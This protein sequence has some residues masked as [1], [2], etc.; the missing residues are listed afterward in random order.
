MEKALVPAKKV[1]LNDLA[2]MGGDKP[3]AAVRAATKDGNA[4][5]QEAAT[6]CLLAWPDTAAIPDMLS[7]ARSGDAKF[8]TLALRGLVQVME[9][10][11]NRAN[12]DTY[13]QMLSI[14]S[15]PAEKKLVIAG[16]GNTRGPGALDLLTPLLADNDVKAEAATSIIK[17][18]RSARGA[19]A[20]AALQKVVDANISDDITNR[21]KAA[22]QR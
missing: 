6:R 13:K 16:L 9:R 8:K 19:A 17:L 14:A 1:L 12:L 3:L 2:K 15:T 11:Q 10:N 18:A 4:E 20:T 7:I 21:A 22:M 5:V